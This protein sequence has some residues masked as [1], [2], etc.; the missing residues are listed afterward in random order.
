MAFYE[1]SNIFIIFNCSE[2]NYI[3]IMRMLEVQTPEDIV[4]AGCLKFI[5]HLDKILFCRSAGNL[6]YANRYL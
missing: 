6:F 4:N 2:K 3:S 1:N 5:N